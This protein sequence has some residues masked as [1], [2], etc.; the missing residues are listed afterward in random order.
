MPSSIRKFAEVID[1]LPPSAADLL[2]ENH[3][4]TYPALSCQRLTDKQIE[5]LLEKKLDIRS[6]KNLYWS[7]SEDILARAVEVE[8]RKSALL[9]LVRRSRIGHDLQKKLARRKLHPEVVNKLAA[10]GLVLAAAEKMV[11]RQLDLSSETIALLVEP[12][13]Q[14]MDAKAVV[15]ALR[16]LPSNRLFSAHLTAS[17]PDVRKILLENPGHSGLNHIANVRL[18][19]EEQEAFVEASRHVSCLAAVASMLDRPTTTEEVRHALWEFHGE[20]LQSR[21]WGVPK[22]DLWPYAPFM[23]DLSSRWREIL[24]QRD[25]HTSWGGFRGWQAVEMLESL[26]VEK[27]SRGMWYHV[28]SG[29]S[30]EISNQ[31]GV[32]WME[33]LNPP[34]TFQLGHRINTAHTALRSLQSRIAACEKFTGVCEIHPPVTRSATAKGEPLEDVV[35]AEVGSWDS[36]RLIGAVSYLADAV[37]DNQDAWRV[38][39]SLADNF[40]G[41]VKELAQAALAAT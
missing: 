24:L 32:A 41:T 14:T 35:F 18:S 13:E 22:P 16:L 8:T 29:C 40:P 7:A 38:M 6:A 11:S 20:N 10:E 34:G 23:G 5:K 30:Q 36:Y 27:H 21:L 2:V 17:R 33:A 26:D 1:L 4:E 19:V 9:V 37:G 15:A 28:T 25:P 31:I 3:P 39:F 12:H